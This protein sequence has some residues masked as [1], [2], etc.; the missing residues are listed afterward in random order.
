IRRAGRTVT[1]RD[2][3]NVVRVTLVPGA[4]LTAATLRGSLGRAR[5]GPVSSLSLPGGRALRLTYRTVS[6]QNPVTARRVT[7]TVDR[8][9]VAGKGG[10]AVIDLGTPVGVDNVD[11]YR[12]M[13]HSF[14]WR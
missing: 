7:P 8:Y 14:R 12:L 1:F 11:A 10:S 9:A 5:I 4:R 3:N 2:R 6:P 13:I